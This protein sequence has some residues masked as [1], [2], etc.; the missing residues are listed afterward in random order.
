GRDRAGSINDHLT[1][2][3]ELVEQYDSVA[4]VQSVLTESLSDSDMN[5]DLRAAGLPVIS[6][7][8]ADARVPRA[9][10]IFGPKLGAFYANLTGAE[11]YLT[12]DLWW[13][14]TIN[15]YRGDVLSAVS[16]LKNA[17]DSKGQPIGL[18][19]FKWLVG[20]PDLT[21]AQALKLVVDHAQR[22][23]DKGYKDGTEA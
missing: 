18:H 3:A 9:V 11:G 23:A 17:V 13:T 14:R 4:E 16:G 10:A 20:Q 22:Y 6:K 1:R 2:I 5:K 21:D 15:R 19:R 8:P 7:M 12:M